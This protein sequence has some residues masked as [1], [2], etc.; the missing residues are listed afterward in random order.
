MMR[1]EKNEQNTFMGRMH[2]HKSRKADP[3][4]FVSALGA[5][6]GECR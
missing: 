3:K 1:G 6:P 2:H 5:E 4:R